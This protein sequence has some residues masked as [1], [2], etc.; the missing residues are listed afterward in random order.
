[1]QVFAKAFACQADHRI[2]GGQNGLRA[3]VILLQRNDA[4]ARTELTRKIKDV[5]H[6]G[7]PETVDRLG[8]VA[9][10][11]ETG[12]V[13]LEAKENPGLQG[14]GVLIFV[15]QNVI[16]QPAHR[17]RQ[18]GYLHELCP[19]EEQ[20]VIVEHTLAL[21]GGNVPIEELTELESPFCAPGKLL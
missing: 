19:V 12:T 15:D 7:G 9:N 4:R 1:M 17:T 18:I 13:G 3:A 11:R 16:K 21:F 10:Y 8:V 5:A 20:V 14:I 6:I 2:R